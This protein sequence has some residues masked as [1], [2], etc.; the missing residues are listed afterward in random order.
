MAAEHGDGHVSASDLR[1]LITQVEEEYGATVRVFLVVRQG[2]AGY[3]GLLVGARLETSGGAVCEGIPIHTT[4]FPH[5]SLRTITAAAHACV[6]GLW[7]SLDY[8]RERA[9]AQGEDT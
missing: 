7:Y 9:A 1:W 2:E 8:M 6:L 3:N 5:S 4:P